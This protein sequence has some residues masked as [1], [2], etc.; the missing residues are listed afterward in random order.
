MTHVVQRPSGPFTIAEGQLEVHQ[1]PLGRDNLGW[2]LVNPATKGCAL[3][4]GP[5]AQP[6]LDHVRS[7]GLE[8]KAVFNTHLHNDHIG[9]NRALGARLH[10]LKVYGAAKTADGIPG[11]THPVK[12][13]DTI[14]FEGV[15]VEVWLTEGHL[16][17]HL[18]YIVDGAVFCGDTMFAGGCGYLFD[19]P[20]E[21]MHSS[22][23]RLSNLPADTLVCCAHEYTMDNLRFA[24]MVEPGNAALA[25]R[26]A[27]VWAIRS[28]GGS[29]VPSTIGEERATNPFLR[30]YSE[31]IQTRTARLSGHEKV[32][33]SAEVFHMVR[34]LKDGG[35]HK[36]LSDDTL[37]T[38]YSGVTC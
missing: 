21:T 33:D 5:N 10:E 38:T 27:S 15:P 32:S 12:D 30:S 36:S 24:W 25:E 23:L 8:L 9:V 34:R 11:L 3:I 20:P 26:I 14:W 18:S 28:A 16:D 7:F 22:L 17:G 31:E 19:G 4:D 2:L 37:P 1:I 6:Y 13:G 29:A 35:M